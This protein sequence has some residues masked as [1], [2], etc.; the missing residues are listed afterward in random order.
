MKFLAF[1]LIL[2]PSLAFAQSITP[3]IP[4]PAEQ[5]VLGQRLMEE[6]NKAI[7]CDVEKVK[8]VAR[9]KELEEQLPKTADKK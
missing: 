2:C 4:A 8:L 6:F 5:Q 3:P 7:S 9:I 1:A